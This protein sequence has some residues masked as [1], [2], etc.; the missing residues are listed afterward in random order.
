MPDKRG[1]DTYKG[2]ESPIT[3]GWPEPIR[4]EVRHV[5]GAWRTKHPGE[6]PRI[7]A[8]GSR[9]AWF[10]A[11]RKYPA[12]YRQHV[13]QA[14]RL[15]TETR[16][17]MKEHPWAGQRTAR[18]IASDH[19]TRSRKLTVKRLRNRV[20]G[21][22][23]AARQERTWA[24]TAGLE[25]QSEHT[26]AVKAKQKGSVPLAKELEWDSKQAGTWQEKRI[27]RADQLDKKADTIQGD[28][29]QMR[30]EYVTGE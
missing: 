27:R 29:Q 3:T 4:R 22:R 11:K 30:K 15:Q 24:G 8:R 7:K 23:A 13:R 6:D 26:R 12:L 28:I 10:A 2:Y 14:A 25:A 1:P 18:R 19:L 9:I 20:A 21:Y 17:E 16:Q 5:Y